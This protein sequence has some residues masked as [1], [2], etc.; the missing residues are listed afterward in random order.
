MVQLNRNNITNQYLYGQLTIPTNLAD[1]SL[2][3]P[4]DAT[5]EVEV[6]EVIFC[7]NCCLN[8]GSVRIRIVS[9]QLDW[10]KT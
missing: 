1:D 4:K 2:I 5:T 6:D 3:R 10:C 9:V 8:A 7:P